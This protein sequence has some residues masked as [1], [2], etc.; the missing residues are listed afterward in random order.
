MVYK[1][2]L[3]ILA[4]VFLAIGIGLAVAASL[5]AGFPHEGQIEI[6]CIIIGF[7]FLVVWVI[8]VVVAEVRG[9]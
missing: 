6:A 5:G 7:V 4:I 3:L 2:G 1:E 8:L 9:K